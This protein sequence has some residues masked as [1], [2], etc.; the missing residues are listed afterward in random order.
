MIHVTHDQEEAMALGDRVA[1]LDSGR[2]RQLDRPQALYQRPADRFVAGFLGWPPMIALDGELIYNDGRLA[3]RSALGDWPVPPE[4]VEWASCAGRRVT[5]GLRPEQVRLG[6]RPADEV[7]L[8][9][10]VR[11]VERLGPT[12]LVTL[13]RDGWTVTL[14]RPASTIPAVGSQASVAFSLAEAHLFDAA[15]GRALSHGR[16]EG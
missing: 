1:V 7:V 14:R 6:S 15:T 11:L 2:V 5:L 10:E 12:D 3:F 13:A 16:P 4:R 9:M 8:A